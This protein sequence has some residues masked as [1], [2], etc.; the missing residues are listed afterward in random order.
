MERPVENNAP[1]TKM[2]I[3]YNAVDVL[4]YTWVCDGFKVMA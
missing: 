2:I 1:Q 3:E 4:T